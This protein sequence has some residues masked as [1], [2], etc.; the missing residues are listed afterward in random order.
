VALGAYVT[1]LTLA[2]GAYAQSFGFNVSANGTGLDTY[3]V[4]TNGAAFGIANNSSVTILSLLH[5][6]DQ[7]AAVST[8]VL[9]AN[10]AA[11]DAIFS[12]IEQKGGVS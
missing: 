4:G 12:A 5:D 6:A 8:T 9:N 11:I 2:G 1:D 3:N 10:L 7:V